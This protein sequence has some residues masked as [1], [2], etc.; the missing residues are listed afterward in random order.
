MRKL[1]GEPALGRAVDRAATSVK[2]VGDGDRQPERTRE[3]ERS[4]IRSAWIGDRRRERASRVVGA[5]WL[6]QRDPRRQG[7]V[8]RR[9]VDEKRPRLAH[10]SESTR[11]RHRLR[12]YQRGAMA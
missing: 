2:R 11:P 4:L 12:G 8:W 1:G 9:L 3:L 6:P 7:A 10:F 5:R